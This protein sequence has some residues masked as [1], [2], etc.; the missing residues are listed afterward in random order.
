M[1]VSPLALLEPL[2]VTEKTE[3]VGVV[4]FQYPASFATASV[5]FKN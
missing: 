1:Y 3:E 4:E 5:V 2:D